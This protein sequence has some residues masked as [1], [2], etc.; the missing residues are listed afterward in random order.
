MRETVHSLFDSNVDPPTVINFV[1]QIVLFNDFFRDE[2][3]FQPH[4]FGT[5]H[6][7]LEIEVLAI[8]HDEYDPRGGYD[9]VEK[10]FG[11][12]KICRWSCY[13]PWIIDEVA[14]DG[15]SCAFLFLFLRPY[16]DNNST[17]SDVLSS[18]FGD[19]GSVDV[20]HGVGAWNVANALSKS[21][22][23]VCIAGGPNALVLV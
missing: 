11:C 22:E 15:E 23:F 5:F 10:E 18:I 19:L 2:A 1:F 17:V 4:E 3:Q 21:S 20:E 8:Q 6:G 7:S 12:G 14:A 16:D 13:L 9:G